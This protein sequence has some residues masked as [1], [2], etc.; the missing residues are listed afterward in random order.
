MQ[1]EKAAKVGIAKWTIIANP[2][3][4][5]E[6][7]RRGYHDIASYR[8]RTGTHEHNRYPETSVEVY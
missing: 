7:R 4:K 6:T 5:K 8:R 2:I 1:E 3:P